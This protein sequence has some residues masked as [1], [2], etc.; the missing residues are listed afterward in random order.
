[1]SWV[2]FGL[3]HRSYKIGLTERR[4]QWFQKW[5]RKVAHARYVHM[6]TFEE[7][8]GRVMYVAGALEYERP[9]LSPLYRFL[10]LHP[11][12]SV[13]R[14]P[15]YVVLILRYLAD[16][17]QECRHYDCAAHIT[18]TDSAPRVDA[19][20]SESRTGVGGWCPVLD[21]NGVRDPGKSRWFSMEVNKQ[22]FS[23]VYC[24][25]DRATRV[26]ATLESLAF[27]PSGGDQERRKIRLQPTW[28]DNRGNGAALNKLMSTQFPL[29]AVV[30][31]LA[32]RCKRSRIVLVVGWTPRQFNRE[33]DDLAN[34]RTQA[35]DPE[36]EVKMNPEDLDWFILPQAL[37]IGQEADES[38][39][40]L[41]EVGTLPN[42]GTQAR[43]R[44]PEQQLRLADPW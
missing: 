27:Y 41:K 25:G 35:F 16:Q 11:R 19:Q 7:G 23:W 30:M 17:V 15:S 6:S 40:R 26:I 42:W 22:D 18:T 14:L 34:G 32:V 12:G 28:T 31:E 24:R 8:L 3:L 43:R 1:M 29:N 10:T 39:W 21:V 36:L 37:K 38:Y 4:A 9:F 20:A 33:A 44:K 2:G 5:T 13:R